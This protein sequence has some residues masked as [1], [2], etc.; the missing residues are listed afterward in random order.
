MARILIYQPLSYLEGYLQFDLSWLFLFDHVTNLFPPLEPALNCDDFFYAS[1]FMK[2]AGL[3]SDSMDELSSQEMDY[4]YAVPK[5]NAKNQEE[6]SETAAARRFKKLMD[7]K[8]PQDSHIIYY[9]SKGHFESDFIEGMSP[10]LKIA[11]RKFPIIDIHSIPI[12]EFIDFLREPETIA[13]KRAFCSTIDDIESWILNGEI[14]IHHVPDLISS[15][16][17]DYLKRIG[18]LKKSLVGK[19]VEF[20][21]TMSKNLLGTLSGIKPSPAASS[22]LSLSSASINLSREEMNLPNGELAYI[23]HVN[24]HFNKPL[25][26]QPDFCV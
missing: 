23:E 24:D 16:Y 21:I 19:S 14:D 15:R 11:I 2:Q 3:L 22:L 8:K 12:S 18:R 9:A 13:K 7:V 10:L 6:F 1:L 25:I 5:W 26:S 17:F 20:V 4:L